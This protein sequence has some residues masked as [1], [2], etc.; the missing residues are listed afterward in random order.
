MSRTE[1]STSMQTTA[2]NDS[3][4][5]ATIQGRIASSNRLNAEVPRFISS[6]R[7]M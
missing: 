4:G 2:S 7:L 1:Q 3:S 5:M 6:R